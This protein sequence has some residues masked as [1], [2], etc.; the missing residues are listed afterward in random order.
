MRLI[1]EKR[2]ASIRVAIINLEDEERDTCQA[3][4][5]YSGHG[6]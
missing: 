6:N 4:L 1:C 3:Q 2:I 5:P